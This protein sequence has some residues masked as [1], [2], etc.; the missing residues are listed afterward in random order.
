MYIYTVISYNMDII[1]SLLFCTI[2]YQFFTTEISKY[3][4]LQN[5]I[6]KLYCLLPRV[7]IML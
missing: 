3:I 7:R 1:G 6:Q 5:N 4:L 2:E